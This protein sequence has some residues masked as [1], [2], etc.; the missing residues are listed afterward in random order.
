MFQSLSDRLSGVL[1]KLTRRG[2]LTETDVAEAMRE[3]RRA[4]LEADV[5]LDVVKDF[6]DQVKAKAVGQEVVKSVTPGQMVVKIV[7]DE[8]VRVLGSDAEPISLAAAPPVA[9][10]MVGLQGSGKTT[11]T[12]KI[13]YRLKNRDRK[14]V[15]MASLDTRR[16]A[17]QEQLRVLGEQTG[18]DTLPIVSGQQPVAIAKRATEA[19]RLGGY[20]VV[21]LDTAGRISIDEEL[22]AEAAA[23]KAATNPHETL[24]VV[25]SLTGQ[26]AV[27][28]AKQFD[29]R[30]GITGTVLTRADGDGRGG[31]ALSMRAV[32]GKPIKL[33]GIG[34]KWDALEEFDPRR[35]A[36]RILGMGDIVGLVE[37]AAESFDRDKALKIAQ[38]MKKGEFDLEDMADQLKQMEKLGGM[39]SLMGMMPGVAKLKGQINEKGLDKEL[40]R[41]RAIISSMTPKERR[42]PKVLD[43]KRKR[44]IAAGSGTKVEDINK[45]LKMHRGM[46]DMMKAM[47]KN[48]GMMS[49][50]AGAMGL[51]PGAG[52]PSEAEMAKMQAELA[53]LDPKALESLPAELK[54]ALP[55]GL[56]GGAGGLPKL[57]GLGGGG[58][59]KGLPGLG[60]G[61]LPRLPGLPGKK[62]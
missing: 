22:M 36:G 25:D 5:A 12:A 34:E 10:L 49:R 28:T 9:I 13:A 39:G 18:I 60:G 11:S 38:R 43:A 29:G 42:A 40:K 59:P 24:L 33:L 20:D 1:D 44:R 31:A 48:K 47:G 50:M 55:K 54:D 46:A 27:N 7:H 4:L 19:A 56:P 32:T 26:D 58:L 53:S 57:P 15:L 61:G 3:V 21:L 16:P 35:V 45:L 41:Q 30:I 52:M 6:V 37:K 62:K 17:A 51:G 2:A 8:L 14:K 23:V